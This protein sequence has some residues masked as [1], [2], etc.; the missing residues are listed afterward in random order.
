MATKD[1]AF[2][3]ISAI[4]NLLTFYFLFCLRCKPWCAQ[5][6]IRL[7]KDLDNVQV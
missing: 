2:I 4:R 5:G 1:A 7:K 6:I 3:S